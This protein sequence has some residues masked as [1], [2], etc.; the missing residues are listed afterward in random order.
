M[1]CTTKYVS[2][3]NGELIDKP[4]RVFNTLEDAIKHCKLMNSL[5]ERKFKIVSYKCK[6]CHKFHVGR[7]GN[8]I[9]NKEKNKFKEA[10]RPIFKVIGKID[11]K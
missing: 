7:N 1:Q 2:R 8:E 11:L 4:K 9:T 3:I 5:P 6:V 10:T